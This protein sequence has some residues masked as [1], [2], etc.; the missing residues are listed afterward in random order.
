[1]DNYIFFLSKC[2]GDVLNVNE[3][4]RINMDLRNELH[5]L[6]NNIENN[7]LWDT[8]KRNMNEYEIIFS[9]SKKYTKICKKNPISR[10]YFKLWEILKDFQPQLFNSPDIP[11]T[12]AHIAE[13]PGGFIEC[14]ID[15]KN[16]YNIDVKSIFGITL[17][18]QSDTENKVPF[19]K[20]NK[21]VCQRNNIFIN[22]KMENIG[23]LY[24]I[25]NIDNFVSKVGKN[26]CKLVTAD[27]GFDFSIDFNNQEYSFLRLFLSEIYTAV[28]VQ[29]VGGSFIIK[30]FD[31]FT[32]ETNCLISIL[33]ELYGE[34][35]IIKPF[36][37]R[38]ANSEKYL[39]C[40][41]FKGTL[42]QRLLNNMRNEIINNIG[43]S[44]SLAKYYND[45]IA[46]RLSV[47]NTYYTNRQMNYLK[48]TLSEAEKLRNAAVVEQDVKRNT[49]DYDN[50]ILWCKK[51]DI[52]F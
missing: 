35:Y 7:N 45:S 24:D 21:D 43:I 30:I 18:I 33:D 44:K 22:R 8:A 15:F 51:Y 12:T 17:L 16:K 50:C 46:S 10:A 23:D 25:R 20:I 29:A 41:K 4:N 9:S 1:M 14:L 48:K 26:K 39:V 38:P 49:S 32:Y 52:D 37:S 28:S 5:E 27:G 2:E 13:G 19:W 42:N 36:T 40:S 11:L 6:K 31:I 3:I 34:I 47:Y